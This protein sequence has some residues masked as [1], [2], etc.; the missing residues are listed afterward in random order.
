MG[1]RNERRN[2]GIG[3]DELAVSTLGRGLLGE[4][5]IIEC[6]GN[7]NTAEVNRG[8]GGDDV[9]LVDT[10]EGDTVEVVWSW[11]GKNQSDDI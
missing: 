4:E 3:L 7:L 1:G 2:L 5:S 6:V 9:G 11:N 8:R 10:A